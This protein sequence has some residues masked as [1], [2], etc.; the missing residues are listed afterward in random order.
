[1]EYLKALAT[2]ASVGGPVDT[3][4]VEAPCSRAFVSTALSAFN[5]VL[6]GGRVILL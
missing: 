6:E 5:A 3:L 4:S 2:A 1:M